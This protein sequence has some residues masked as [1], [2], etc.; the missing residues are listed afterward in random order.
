MNNW[1]QG[2]YLSLATRKRDGSW[3]Y[4]PVWFAA[5]DGSFYIFSEGKAGK[6]K[7]IR[8]FQDVRVAP[9]TVS[10]KITGAEQT[11]IAQ[12]LVEDKDKTFAH[13]ALVNKYGWQMRLLDLG[14][15]LARKKSKRAFVKIQLTETPQE[16]A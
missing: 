14:S 12:I 15:A 3:V 10:G 2:N 8:N 11:G 7:R 13:Q 5:L 9:C 1:T 6:I 16:Q 4:T